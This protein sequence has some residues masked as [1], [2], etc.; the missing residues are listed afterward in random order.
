M[1]QPFSMSEPSGSVFA[2]DLPAAEGRELEI[3]SIA[4]MDHRR[5]ILLEGTF[6]P[7]GAMTANQQPPKFQD[8]RLRHLSRIYQPAEM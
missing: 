3:R 8:L 5:L 4:T 6:M 2:F 1:L 7:I